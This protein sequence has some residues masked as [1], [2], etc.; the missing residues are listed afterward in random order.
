MLVEKIKAVARAR[1]ASCRAGLTHD[2]AAAV[3]AAAVR[4]A[5]LE[6]TNK[7][8]AI[9]A[10]T[11]GVQALTCVLSALPANAPGTVVVQHMPAHFTTSFAERLNNECA[12]ARQGGPGW[13]P[14]RSR[15]G[16]DR[17]GRPAHAPAAGPAPTISS[18]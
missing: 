9:G 1:I 12:V 5:W 15:P 7:I 11:G 14:R 2:R 16:A 4:R 13:R 17:P 6:T 8:F 10:S 18:H 3:H